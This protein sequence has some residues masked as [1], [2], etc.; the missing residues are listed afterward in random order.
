MMMMSNRKSLAHVH[1]KLDRLLETVHL[2]PMTFKI[3]LCHRCEHF[4]SRNSC[5]AYK[6]GEPYGKEIEPSSRPASVGPPQTV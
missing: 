6:G 3:S 4:G 5:R 1:I 2:V